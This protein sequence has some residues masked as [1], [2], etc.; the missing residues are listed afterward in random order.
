MNTHNNRL[1]ASKNHWRLFFG[2]ALANGVWLALFIIL[3]GLHVI[4]MYC[5]WLLCRHIH[6][7]LCSEVVRNLISISTATFFYLFIRSIT[8]TQNEIF[9]LRNEESYITNWQTIKLISLVLWVIIFIIIFGNGTEGIISIAVV[10]TAL[11]W[12]FQDSIKGVVAFY[13]LRSNEMIR[14]GD[15]I[16][17]DKFG[18]DGRIKTIALTSV[19]VENWDTTTSSVP[20]C[21]LLSEQV[22]NLQKMSK[23]RTYGRRMLRSFIID[24]GW[25]HPLTAKEVSVISSKVAESSQPFVKGMVKEGALNM[26]LFREYIRT[27]LLNHSK[28]SHEPRLI[29]RWMEHTGEGIPLQVYAFL[30]ETKLAPFEKAQSEITEH[31][32]ESIEWFGLKLYQTPSGYDA[33]NS[34]IYMTNTEAKY[35]RD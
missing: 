26:Q 4:S 6:I 28:V 1:L 10:G 35:G 32:L 24:T 25:V 21:E 31:I 22:Q 9:C 8:I 7:C 23:G 27:Y 15:W 18:I 33:S 12:I 3:C 13:H 29:V 2:A 17:V 16:K 11:S 20:M 14:I 5:P 30:L 34:N 19:I